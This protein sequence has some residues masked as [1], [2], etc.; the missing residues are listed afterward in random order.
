MISILYLYY[1][2]RIILSKVKAC[3]LPCK[4]YIISK[5]LLI[6]IALE[7]ALPSSQM[8]YCLCRSKILN[9]R[10]DIISDVK[11]SINTIHF[12]VERTYPDNSAFFV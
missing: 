4:F 2:V 11:A 7:I 12:Y 10:L 6:S 9:T 5:S 8:A 1:T 3:N